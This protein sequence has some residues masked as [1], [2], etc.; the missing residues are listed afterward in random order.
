MKQYKK[1]SYPSKQEWLDNRG[2]GG[3]SAAAICNQSKWLTAGDVYNELALHKHKKVSE[4]E[5]MMEGTLTEPSIRNLFSF[6][7]K[8]K[9]IVKNPPKKSFWLFR[10]IDKPYITL[11]PDG[12]LK[13]I[14]TNR[15]GALEIKNVEMIKSDIRQLW[16]NNMLPVQYYYQCLHYFIAKPDIEFV[17][18][19]AHLKYYE[20]EGKEWKFSHAIDKAYFIEKSDVIADIDFLEKKETSF[21]EKHILVKKRPAS[22]ISF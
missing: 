17:V 9:Y 3:S 1:E 21:Y 15:N 18:L 22:I 5:R 16:E 2:I 13:E 11:T 7:F 12:L 19:Y 6:D 20:L 10:R 4:N 14:K 8:N